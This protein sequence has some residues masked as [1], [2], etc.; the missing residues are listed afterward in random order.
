[1]RWLR[2]VLVVALFSAGCAARSGVIG[3]DKPSPDKT[4]LHL[5]RDVTL[6]IPNEFN[7]NA[8]LADGTTATKKPQPAKVDPQFPQLAGLEDYYRSAPELGAERPGDAILLSTEYQ[9]GEYHADIQVDVVWSSLKLGVTQTTLK[10]ADH[11]QLE[12]FASRQDE[13]LQKERSYVAFMD[14]IGVNGWLTKGGYPVLDYEYH[15]KRGDMGSFDLDYIYN[16]HLLIAREDG[17]ILVWI[18]MPVSRLKTWQ[19]RMD[20]LVQSLTVGTVK[21]SE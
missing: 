16:R 3:I 14:R 20:E 15:S 13:S 1:M 2:L 7:Y 17:A 10:I 4:T 5:A 11:D 6:T 9:D 19:G 12:Q 18:Q 21:A 8:R